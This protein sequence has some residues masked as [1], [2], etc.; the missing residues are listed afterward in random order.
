MHRLIA[1]ISQKAARNGGL[2]ICP[3]PLLV[4]T[5]NRI[6]GS[7]QLQKQQGARR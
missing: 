4:N 1:G 7:F 2:F 3:L 6:L 5:G